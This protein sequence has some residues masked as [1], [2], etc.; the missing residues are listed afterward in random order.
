MGV[1]Q[2]LWKLGWKDVQWDVGVGL[3]IATVEFKSSS[4]VYDY[5][6]SSSV[7]IGNTRTMFS[8]LINTELKVF[9]TDHFSIGLAADLAYIPED[10]PSVQGITF[11]SKTLG[12]RSV[13]FV[14]G[15]HL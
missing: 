8:A 4:Q 14:L 1:I 9:V 6:S 15:L 7:S 10:V 13:G 11:E 3:G 12:T 5:S 2:P